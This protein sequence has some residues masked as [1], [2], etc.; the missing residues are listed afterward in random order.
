[1]GAAA[2]GGAA[3]GEAVLRARGTPGPSLAAPR[4]RRLGWGSGAWAGGKAP[5]AS[6]LPPQ[7]H[8]YSAGARLA[9][10]ETWQQPR[11]RRAGRR[12]GRESQ[13]GGGGGAACLARRRGSSPTSGGRLENGPAPWPA[14]GRSTVAL[15]PRVCRPLRQALLPRRGK[16][17]FPGQLTANGISFLAPMQAFHGIQQQPCCN[18]QRHIRLEHI[19]RFQQSPAT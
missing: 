16:V 12:P 11:W 9:P 18:R 6:P 19:P 1:M 13:G 14:A 17:T 3:E 5:V 15:A 4:R 8:P 10:G 7:P 2:A